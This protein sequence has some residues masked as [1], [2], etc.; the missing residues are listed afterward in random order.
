[1]KD[2]L[3]KNFRE[4]TR[5]ELKTRDMTLAKL[6]VLIGMKTS[7]LY[8]ILSLKSAHA[9]TTV[10]MEKISDVLEIPLSSLTSNVLSALSLPVSATLTDEKMK[11]VEV[12]Q[13][14]WVNNDQLL[15]KKGFE[16]S[17]F[18]SFLNDETSKDTANRL[19]LGVQQARIA[20]KKGL[21]NLRKY[22]GSTGY[23]LT[24]YSAKYNK[25][26]WIEH[27]V[28]YLDETVFKEE[29]LCA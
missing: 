25:S 18:L 1:M 20:V 6:A 9:P 4:N 22:T 13:E 3:V 2:I 7:Y 16:V 21:T 15:L 12:W 27:A 26:V 14:S 11:K 23:S 29:L 10:T 8:N 19:N 28:K 5:Q 24:P 17:L